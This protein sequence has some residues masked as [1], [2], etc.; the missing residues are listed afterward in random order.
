MTL[1]HMLRLVHQLAH[2]VHLASPMQTVT[3]RLLV[4][5]A[6]LAS[7]PVLVRLSALL[8]QPVVLIWT[9]MHRRCARIVHRVSTVSRG[10]LR[11]QT[12]KWGHTI[13]TGALL[14]HA[15]LAKV[16]NMLQ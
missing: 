10:L 3:H 5:H 7:I 15:N 8:V 2:R 11:V 13:T 4:K 12:V 6:L 16:V 1:G 9:V 14:P